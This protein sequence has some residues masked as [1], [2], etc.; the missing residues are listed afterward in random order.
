[1]SRRLCLLLFMAMSAMALPAL[2][3]LA[4]A[5]PAAAPAILGP[6]K[7]VDGDTLRLGAVTVRLHGIDA[8]EHGQTCPGVRG[9][10]WRCGQAAM[11]RLAELA[12]GRALDCQPLDRDR[13]GRIVA[14]CRSGG[15]DLG[16]TLVAEGLAWAYHRYSS[17][18]AGI[19]AKARTR[20]TGV[21]Q[22]DTQPA[23]TYR[24]LGRRR[25]SPGR[26][27][28]GRRV[29][30]CSGPVGSGRLSASSP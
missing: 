20:R 22:A 29:P 17:D 13:Y 11:A 5:L 24:A 28:G 16:A 14:A 8:P 6:A 21:W 7:V 10:Q 4:T 30:D 27:D 9:G 3:P 26:A 18:Y 15:Q 23:W 25:C 12:A 19:E 1:M 2:A